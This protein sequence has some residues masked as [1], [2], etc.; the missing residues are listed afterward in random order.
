MNL[1]ELQQIIRSA[2]REDLGFGDLTGRL[3][4]RDHRTTGLFTVKA[5]GVLAGVDVI[6]E[7]Y[8]ILDPSV[9]VTLY[10][11]DGDPVN[12]G[13]QI[14]EA[15]GPTAVLLGG[16]R[17]ILNLLQHLSGIASATKRAVEALGDSSAKV[18]DTRKT[19]PGLRMLQKFAVRCGGGYNHRYRLDDGVIIK[20]NHI[21]AAGSIGNAVKKIRGNS[22]PMVR[23]EVETETRQQ[24]Q[25]AVESG[26]DIIMFDNRNPAEVKELVELVPDHIITEVSGGITPDTIGDYRDTGVDFISLGYLTHSVNALDISFNL[27]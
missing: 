23:I 27:I 3:F 10:K 2:L 11:Q 15:E 14:A 26:A 12:S 7:A 6:S 17:V 22:G 13:E 18:C 19:L 4:P 5:D 25:E 16:E 9:G 21:S 24:V 8:R 1:P 20:E